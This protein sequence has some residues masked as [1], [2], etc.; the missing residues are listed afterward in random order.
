MINYQEQLNDEQFKVVRE[1]EGPCLVLAGAGS[2]KTRT[3]I[4]RLAHLLSNGT[5]PK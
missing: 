3:I 4:Y 2:G 5:D 1:G